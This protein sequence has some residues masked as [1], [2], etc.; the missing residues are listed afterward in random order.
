MAAAAAPDFAFDQ[1]APTLMGL[2][3][4][5]D[6]TP[7]KVLTLQGTDGT[8]AISLDG[9]G[10]AGVKNFLNTLATTK[11][12]GL[13]T[14]WQGGP[15]FIAHLPR[16]YSFLVPMAIGDCHAGLGNLDEALTSYQSTLQYPSINQAYEVVKV[17]TRMAQTILDQGDRAYRLAGDDASAYAAAKA[18]YEQL[19]HADRTVDPA[20]PLYGP[21]PFG[22]IK[23]RVQAF[24]AESDPLAPAENPAITTLL[25]QALSRLS[26]M[27]SGLNFFGFGPNYV[28]PFSFEYLQNTARYFAEHASQTEQR[29]IQYKSQAENEQFRRDQM[30]QQ[31]QVAQQTVVL[32]Q[33]NLDEAQRGIDVANA[34][35]NYANVQTQNAISTR[36]D[37]QNARAELTELTGLEAWANAASV[38][39]DDEVQLTT[40][41]YT[42]FQADS[43]RRSIVLQRLALQRT[44]IS[45]QLEANK[46]DR[47]VTSAQAYQG[48]AQAQLSE[49]QARQAVAQQRVAIAQLQQR[50]AEESRDF[51]DMREFSD[52]LWYELAQEAKRIKQRYLDMATEAALLM[53]RAYNAETER[54]IHV[55]RFDYDSTAAGNLMGAD[56]LLV[57]IDSFTL[58]R[59]TTT[60]RK[61]IP[62]KKT[63]SLADAY[64]T[65]FQNLKT[66]GLCMFETVLA[67][68]DR[69]H[70]GLYLAKINNVELVFVGI[71]DAD[72]LAGTF[73]NI[74]VSRFRGATGEII[75]RL[76]PA[77]VMALSQYEIRQDSLLFRFDPNELRLFENNGVETLWQLDLPLSANDFDYDGILDVHV[78][79][80]FDA[81]FDPSLETTIRASLPATGGGARGFSMRLTFPDELFYLKNQGEGDLI[82]D[83]SLFPLNQLNLKRNKTTI[84]LIGKAT[85]V[86]GLKL[87]LTS[88][89]LATELVLTA[90]AQG[91]ILD[92]TPGSPLAQFQN[93]AVLDGWHFKIKPEDN[94]SLVVNGSLDLSGLDDVMTFTDYTFTYR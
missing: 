26:Q 48:V 19:V 65:Q 6:A 54:N 89:Q 73:R 70:P 24:L 82:V 64:P 92:S 38:D 46:L 79:L 60:Q 32:E 84:K 59:I 16:V 67:D 85:T 51:L 72:S 9:G 14:Q 66:K 17:W 58:D 4:V 86:N 31:A 49:A 61:K 41:G 87:R 62:V 47:A 11:D 53:E 94:P 30:D 71:S 45:N 63:I 55:I 88:D 22:D 25:L 81:F 35:L 50:F 18:F 2:T 93:R 90:D 43:Q 52:R 83:A 91:E 68:F 10:V 37:F 12:V 77:D 34:S 1:S 69:D 33:R 21:A 44:R 76:Y 74:G 57:D 28:P 3:F 23:A 56:Q 27:A 36:N 15:R 5:T 29:Y 8:A 75:E 80:Y 40:S 42:Y 7:K 13:L 39:Q 78:V 20:S